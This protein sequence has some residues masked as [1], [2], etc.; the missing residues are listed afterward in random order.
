VV[1][2]FKNSS[3]LVTKGYVDTTIN[4]SQSN[5]GNYLMINDVYLPPSDLIVVEVPN[6]DDNKLTTKKYVD[7]TMLDSSFFFTINDTAAI[8]N[9]GHYITAYDIYNH[10]NEIN[11]VYYP[12][13]T[14]GVTDDKFKLATLGFVYDLVPDLTNYL[15][16][17]MVYVPPGTT[18]G[19]GTS[20]ISGNS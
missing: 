8:A 2:P 15:T 10:N 1:N 18:S 7:S 13:N 16:A 9:T 6:P 5:L 3:L 11:P 20:G 4:N 17:D 14:S 12:L 19:T